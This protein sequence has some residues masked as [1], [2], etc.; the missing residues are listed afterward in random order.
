[1]VD[2][3]VVQAGVGARLKRS[4]K[5]KKTKRSRRKKTRC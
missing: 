2:E 5:R 1:V 4:P 3:H